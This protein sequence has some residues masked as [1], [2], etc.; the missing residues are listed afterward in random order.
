LQAFLCLNPSFEV[1]CAV[2]A[3]C[4]DRPEVA[5][6]TGLAGQG[7]DGGAFWIKRKQES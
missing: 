4:Q 1:L 2:H 6:V 3:L 7:E 5:V